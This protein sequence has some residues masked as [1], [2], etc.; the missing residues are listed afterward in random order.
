MASFS[1]FMFPFASKFNF[2]GVKFKKK[3]QILVISKSWKNL[4]TVGNNNEFNIITL[5]TKILQ[6]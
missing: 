3:W 6:L 5:N 2:N 4:I 1:N